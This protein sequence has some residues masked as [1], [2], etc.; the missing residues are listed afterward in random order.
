MRRW[1]R[2][3]ERRSFQKVAY[4]RD[5]PTDLKIYILR[6]VQLFRKRRHHFFFLCANFCVCG[7]GNSVGIVTGY[8]LDGQGIESRWGRDF[9]TPVQT[10]PGPH[11]ASCTMATVS[12]PG[13]ESGRD[14]TLTPHPL[15]V[16]MSENRIELYFY[17]T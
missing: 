8:G 12:L 17:Y 1:T 10:G 2:S 11:P 13:V 5:S 6:F 16:P 4:Y 15:L 7:P 9:F 14:V 3:T